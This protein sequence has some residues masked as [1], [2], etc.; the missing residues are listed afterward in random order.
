MA[1]QMSDFT[2][3]VSRILNSWSALHVAVDQGFGGIYSREKVAWLNEVVTKFF[4]ENDAVESFE[5]SDFIGDIL[6]N[7]F[8]LR[9]EDGSLEEISNNLCQCFNCFRTN[10]LNELQAKLSSL[11]GIENVKAAAGRSSVVEEETDEEMEGI[12]DENGSA[13]SKSSNKSPAK[14]VDEDGFTL[15]QS[16]RKGNKS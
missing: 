14:V 6:D 1:Q 15:V 3:V 11:P 13:S 5:V 7:E 2:D 10:N 9:V 12:E 8:N 4:F 16:K